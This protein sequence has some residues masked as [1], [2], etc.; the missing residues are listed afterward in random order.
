SAL[1]RVVDALLAADVPALLLKGAALVETV[2]PDPAQREMLDLDLLVPA[3]RLDEASA[4]LTPLGYGPSPAAGQDARERGASRLPRH[5]HH[6][7]G[8][9]GSKQL[10][11]V[12]LPRHIL[13]AGEGRQFDI[14]ELWQRSRPSATGPHLLPSPED[15]VLHVCLHFARNRVGGSYRR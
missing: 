15:L 8:L 13:I 10:L 3:E 9:L 14:D 7:R 11:A 4:A 5:A 12:E 1:R 6:G 2:Y